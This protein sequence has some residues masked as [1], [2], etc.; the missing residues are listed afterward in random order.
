MTP[1]K[2]GETAGYSGRPLA[3]KLGIKPET[4]AVRTSATD[5]T[6]DTIREVALP[7]GLVDSRSA[8]STRPGRA[9]A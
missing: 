9:C 8:R 5:S 2:A 1:A 6:E 3:Q 4:R 7:R